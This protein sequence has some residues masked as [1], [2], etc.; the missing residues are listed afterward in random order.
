MYAAVYMTGTTCTINGVTYRPCSSVNNTDQRRKFSLE[1][2][3]DGAKYGY[4]AEIDGGGTQSYNGMILTISRRAAQRL[5][6]NANYTLS[7]CVGP[8]ATL[9]GS[10]SLWPYETYT[11]PNNRDADRGDCD[12][13]RR[14]I[15]NV[16]SLWQTPQFSNRVLRI[17]ATG[18][19]LSGIYRYSAGSPLNILAGTDRALNGIMNQRANQVSGNPISNKSAAPLSSYLDP[20]AFAIPDLGTTGNI[21]RNSIAGPGTW[22][23]DMAV[24]R[25]FNVREMQRLEFRAEAFNVTNSFHPDNPNTTVSNNT[26]GVIRTALDPRILQF[27]LKYVF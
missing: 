7:H 1:R 14:H 21:G 12:S 2:P 8:Y 26:F 9:Y 23:L 18:W 22:G 19:R 3:Q 17:A 15:M 24:S 25:V 20:R 27:A 16:T 13:D 11:N 5:V 6:L 4:A 10:L